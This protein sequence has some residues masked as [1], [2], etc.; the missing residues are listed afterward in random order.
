MN[1]SQKIGRYLGVALALAAA[2]PFVAVADNKVTTGAALY[3]K[4]CVSCHSTEKGVNKIGP[5]LDKVIGR[6]AAAVPDYSYSS[7]IRSSALAWTEETLIKFLSGPQAMIPCHQIATKALV[8]CLG[9]KMTF[10]GFRSEASAAAV[11]A[12][13]KSLQ[14]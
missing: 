10:P 3:N 7:I 12:Y 5:T 1:H 2:F 11:V 8:S 6:H 9:T 14:H 13:L 4:A